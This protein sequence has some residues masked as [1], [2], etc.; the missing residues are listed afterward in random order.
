MATVPSGLQ[1]AFPLQ[2]NRN[3]GRGHAPFGRASSVERDLRFYLAMESK[4]DKDAVLLLKTP[5]S[6]AIVTLALAA[7][8]VIGFL[9]GFLP[10]RADRTELAARVTRLQ[11]E[12]ARLNPRV[13]ELQQTIAKLQANLKIA[14]LRGTAGLMSQRANHNN[15]GAA[16]ELSSRFFDGIRE[17]LAATQEPALR[18]NLE[19]ILQQRDTVTSAL[20]QANPAVKEQLAKIYSD[21]F[22]HTAG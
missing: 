11:N 18:D 16:A 21:F 7:L 4:V 12:N 8:F 17:T 6:Y 22:D 13:G 5:V 19:K 1:H 3:V 15:F 20:A 9:L 2:L 14:E 10:A